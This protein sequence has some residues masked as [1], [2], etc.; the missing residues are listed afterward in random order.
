MEIRVYRKEDV[1]SIIS[2]YQNTVRHVLGKHYPTEFIEKFTKEMNNPLTVQRELS[3]SYS[4]VAVEKRE[5]IG[6]GELT[7][8]GTLRHLHVDKNN[9][10]RGAGTRLLKEL[11]RI[12]LANGMDS[13]EVLAT[14]NAVDFFSAR[15]YNEDDPGQR[16][17]L[18]RKRLSSY[19]RTTV[20]T[21]VIKED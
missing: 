16:F 3:E 15:G 7:Y 2:L 13:I 6:F 4:R 12:A 17:T 14:K 19:P 10:K 20:L 21:Q 18:M 8:E 1:M 5:I 9:L 11:E